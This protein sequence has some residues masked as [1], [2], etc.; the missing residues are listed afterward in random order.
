MKISELLK[1]LRAKKKAY[2]D[3]EIRVYDPDWRAYY[4]ID[5]KYIEK[6]NDEGDDFLCL[7]TPSN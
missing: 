5:V 4:N 2:G 3:L 6:T 7:N 1:I